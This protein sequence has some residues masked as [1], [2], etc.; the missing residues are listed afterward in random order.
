MFKKLRNRILLINLVTISILMIFAFGT[1]YFITYQNVHQDINIELHRITDVYNKPTLSRDFRKMDIV[2]PPERSVSFYIQT[3]H[4]WDMLGIITR[5]DMDESFYEEAVEEISSHSNTT[6]QFKLDGNYWAYCITR[7]AFGYGIVLLDITAQHGI[8][9]NLV[10]TFI[11]VGLGMLIVIFFISR[12]F[13]NRSIAPVKEAFEKQKQFIADASHEL[14]TP[15]SIIHT[16]ADV[17]LANSHDTIEDQ[18]KWIYYIKSEAERMSKLTNDLLYLAQIDDGRSQMIFTKFN[19][20]EIVENAILTMESIIFERN[21]ELEYEIAPNLMIRGNPEQIK[22]VVMNLLDNAIK[23]TNPKGTIKLNL[24]K[25]HNEAVLSV[26][27]TGEGIPPSQID[28]IF[29]RFYRTDPSRSSKH[30]GYGLGLA[31]AK[32]IIEQHKGKIYARSIPKESTTF[33]VKLPIV[34]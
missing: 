17:L 31:I 7:N 3:D 27:N 9:I 26:F 16:N 25:Q 8:L 22:Q 4:E 18:L 2:P 13:A 20:S 6:G 23:Y 10:Y 33:Y 15:L 21:L 14:K 1:I 29:D 5:F 11:V 12:Y 28:K 34:S 32:S 30:G 19:L 24:A